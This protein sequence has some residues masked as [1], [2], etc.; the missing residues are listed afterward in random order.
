[1][2]SCLALRPP[3]WRARATLDQEDHATLAQAAASIRAPA[4]ALI[5]DLVGAH[6]LAQAA[7]SIRVPAGALILDLVGAPILVPVEVHI[8]DL[9]EVH[10]PDLAVGV[11]LD[12]AGT[13]AIAGIGPA[14]IAINAFGLGSR[15]LTERPLLVVAAE[16]IQTVAR[17]T[18]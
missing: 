17:R 6:T 3:H 11:T 2:R 1:M 8:P 9:V 15:D 5:L 7:A 10:I 18:F 12:P 13:A 4:G 14:H 16:P